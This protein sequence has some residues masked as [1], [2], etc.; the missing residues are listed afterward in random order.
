MPRVEHALTESAAGGSAGR[1]AAYR[2]PAAQLRSRE[3]TIR[4]TGSRCIVWAGPPRGEDELLVPLQRDHLDG[5]ARHLGTAV[6]RQRESRDDPPGAIGA[7]YIRP[8]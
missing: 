7:G 2:Q 4:S 8:S 3:P 5:P 6:E 1:R